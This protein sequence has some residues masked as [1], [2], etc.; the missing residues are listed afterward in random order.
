MIK[1][2][3]EQKR[4]RKIKKDL[5]D[6]DVDEGEYI[7]EGFRK[8][9]LVTSAKDKKKL[10][11]EKRKEFEKHRGDNKEVLAQLDELPELDAEEAKK[12]ELNIVASIRKKKVQP[13]QPSL[14]QLNF[15][16]LNRQLAAA[17]E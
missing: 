3:D 4:I 8:K 7:D 2:L 16:A 9:M 5:D 12:K 17:Q 11:R 15:I 10:F 1:K 14:T 6:L 13:I